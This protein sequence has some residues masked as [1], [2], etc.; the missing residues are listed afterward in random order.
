MPFQ[1]VGFAGGR[2]PRRPDVNYGPN[3]P[4]GFR[5]PGPIQPTPRAPMPTPQ[6]GPGPNLPSGYRRQDYGVD[7]GAQLQMRRAMQARQSQPSPGPWEL[8]QMLLQ[9]LGPAT[10]KFG[11]ELGQGM[12]DVRTAG[13]QAWQLWGPPITP[14]ERFNQPFPN[15]ASPGLWWRDAWS[16]RR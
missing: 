14:P 10:K 12:Q 16:K 1:N 7:L 3:L 15:N 13:S 2:K 6:L 5:R 11:G 9:Q 4:S 8:I